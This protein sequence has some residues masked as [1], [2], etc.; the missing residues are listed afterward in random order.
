MKNVY[1][2]F[3]WSVYFIVFTFTLNHQLRICNI[4]NGKIMEKTIC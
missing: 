3:E 2:R 1:F 4:N